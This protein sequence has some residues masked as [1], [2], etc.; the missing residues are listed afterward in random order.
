MSEVSDGLDV[1]AGRGGWHYEWDHRRKPHVHPLATPAGVVLTRVEP[2][3]HPWQRGL[4][5]V[6]KFV[7][8]D[9]FWEELDPP[10]YGV[11]RHDGPRRRTGATIEGELDWIRPDRRTVAVRERRRLTHVPLGDDAYAIDWDVT[12]V[13]AADALLDRTPFTGTWGATRGWPSGAGR[14][15]ATPAWSSTTARSTTGWRPGGHGGATCRARPTDSPWACACSTTRPT[16]RT[17]CRSTPAAGPGTAT[18]T[19]GP[20]RCTPRSCGMVPVPWP[21]GEPLRFRYRVVVHDDIWDAARAR[22]RG[23]AG[24][25]GGRRPERMGAL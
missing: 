23:C 1:P 24:P 25:A 6:V 9:N 10:G 21:P 3:D 5:F 20:T 16:R 14:T 15:G 4:W 19:A 7:D 17:R 13:A 22:L 18:A 12:L 11:Q 2:P 8:G